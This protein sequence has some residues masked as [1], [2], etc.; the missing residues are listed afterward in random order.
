MKKHIYLTGFMGAGKSRI[1]R[2]LA[3]E[4]SW[5]FYDTDALI[6]E[7][8][9]QT[10]MK[11]FEE[12]GEPFFRQKETQVIG[13]ISAEAYPAVISLGGGALMQKQNFKIIGETG[14][15]IYIKSA[16]EKI[17][18][19]VEHS[20]KR[21][22]LKVEKDEQFKNRLL[23][24]IIEMLEQREPVYTRADIVYLRDGLDPEQIV[25]ELN[26]LIRQKWEGLNEN[27]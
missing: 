4:W 12:K 22:L 20:D 23:N 17:L 14:L 13:R 19:R 16:P 1:G 26:G 6:E 7:E 9:G 18:E 21:P 3:A 27:D 24:K 5:P 11:L 25:P 8:T 2:T 15:L 10:I